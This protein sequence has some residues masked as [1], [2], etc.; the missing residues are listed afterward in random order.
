MSDDNLQIPGRRRPIYI[1]G[2]VALLLTVYLAWPES[3]PDFVE[4]G[5][6]AG[7]H[8]A[9]RHDTHCKLSGTVESVKIV[10]MGKVLEGQ[11][12]ETMSGVRWFVKL[13]GADVVAALPASRQDVFKWHAAHDRSLFG[14]QLDTVGRMFDPDEEKGYGGIGKALRKTLGIPLDRRIW[15]FDA[16]DVP[17]GS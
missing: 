9:W 6:A 8:P 17:K 10:A 2:G 15:V 3:V 4:C 1:T 12:P 16:A 7:E 11:G 5:D 13:H 14:Y